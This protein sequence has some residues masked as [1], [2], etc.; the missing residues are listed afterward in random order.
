MKAGRALRVREGRETTK[1]GH[2]LRKTRHLL[3][4]ER[5]VFGALCRAKSAETSAQRG[6]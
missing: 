3:S 4:R 6:R 1:K 5:R 2:N